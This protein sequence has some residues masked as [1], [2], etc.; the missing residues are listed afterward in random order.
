MM[1]PDFVLH[2]IFQHLSTDDLHR[3]HRVC[4]QWS[5]IYVAHEMSVS[6]QVLGR[7]RQQAAQQRKL[8]LMFVNGGGKKVKWP[9]VDE[10][11]KIFQHYFATSTVIPHPLV[12]FEQHVHTQH[13]IIPWYWCR[14]LEERAPFPCKVVCRDMGRIARERHDQYLF[15]AVLDYKYLTELWKRV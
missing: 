11:I 4:R 15:S 3:V 14:M 1:F 8:F 9:T 5:Q 7:V 13:R 2:R 6:G 12:S 10:T